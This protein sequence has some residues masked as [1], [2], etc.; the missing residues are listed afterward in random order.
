MALVACNECGRSIAGSAP[1][2]PGCGKRRQ[3]G[4]VARLFLNFVVGV[5]LLSALSA[6]L[7]VKLFS[8]AKRASLRNPSTVPHH[9][10]PAR[11]LAAD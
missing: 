10:A 8:E 3:M 1:V 2:C 11:R 4:L 7:G 5:V 6:F 9:A